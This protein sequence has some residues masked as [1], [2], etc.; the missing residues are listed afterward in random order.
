MGESTRFCEG[1]QILDAILVANEVVDDLV[2]N[3]RD[4]ILCKLDME[5]TYNYVSW[6]FVDYMLG[7]LVLARS[8]GAGCIRVLRLFLL[9]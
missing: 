1:R 5:K 7:R 2:D 3:K 8:G 4:E 9:L 6:E